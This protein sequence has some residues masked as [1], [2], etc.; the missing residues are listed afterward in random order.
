[1]FFAMPFTTVNRL[2]W[3]NPS[4][5]LWLCFTYWGYWTGYNE[6]NA[7]TRKDRYMNISGNKTIQNLIKSKFFSLRFSNL[8]KSL[9]FVA[10]KES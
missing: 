5:N 2:A 4:S 7:E 3:N 8:C 10:N 6:T 1:M 9:C